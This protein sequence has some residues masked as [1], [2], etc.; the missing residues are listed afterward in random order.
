MV[1][2]VMSGLDR[3][4]RIQRP[5]RPSWQNRVRNGAVARPSIPMLVPLHL[6]ICLALTPPQAGGQEDLRAPLVG[7][8][9]AADGTPWPFA[10]VTLWSR[11]HPAVDDG[12]LLQVTADEQGR[13]QVQ[14]LPARSY[15]AYATAKDDQGRFRATRAVVGA[16]VGAPLELREVTGWQPL[17]RLRPSGLG[18]W[19]ERGLRWSLRMA[20]RELP[21]ALDDG[22]VVLP[23][24]PSAIETRVL[25]VSA[26]GIPAVFHPVGPFDGDAELAV[27]PPSPV[28]LRAS[29]RFG[30]SAVGGASVHLRLD[31]RAFRLG[32]TAAD[33]AVEVDL[34]AIAGAGAAP[35]DDAARYLEVEAAGRQLGV[36]FVVDAVARDAAARAA[37]RSDGKQQILAT[38]QRGVA[39][40]GRVLLRPGAPAPGLRLVVVSRACVEHHRGAFTRPTLMRVIAGAADGTFAIEGLEPKGIVRVTAVV[41][42]AARTAIGDGASDPLVPLWARGVPD[43]DDTWADLVL[44]DVPALELAV[45]DI[46]GAPALGAALQ[47]DLAAQGGGVRRTA[48]RAGR[49]RMR[50]APG[51]EV[52]LYARS[53]TGHFL[54]AIVGTADNVPSPPTARRVPLALLP[55]RQVPVV[56]DATDR[57]RVRVEAVFVDGDAAGAAAVPTA[58]GLRRPADNAEAAR[59]AEWAPRACGVD[60]D[61]RGELRLPDVRGRW[62]VQ[63]LQDGARRDAV[64]IE[65]RDTAIEPVRLAW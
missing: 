65:L 36:T 8:V 43:R 38:L 39:V 35:F 19:Q 51:V 29:D 50:I 57:A 60:P 15:V 14:A 47:F 12:D 55:W 32:T 21:L 6:A 63:A 59:L 44:A 56:V 3:L 23:P 11:V 45:A 64:T 33:G 9:R 1:A 62:I 2:A 13:V 22:V 49:F 46:D 37:L 5:S 53:A 52:P 42:A 58:V 54:G 18:A 24:L 7:V 40:R 48:D 28:L 4:R 27:A 25:A 20:G 31:G 61:G 10:M 34:A 26:D 17:P 30:G 41:D 16:T